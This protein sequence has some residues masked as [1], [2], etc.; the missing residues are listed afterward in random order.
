MGVFR[1]RSDLAILL[2]SK[3]T[4]LRP[5]QP[6]SARIP[7]KTCDSVILKSPRETRCL[8]FTRR[9]WSP[10]ANVTSK[11]LGL[12]LGRG[13]TTDVLSPGRNSAALSPLWAPLRGSNHRGEHLLSL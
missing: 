3:T 10:P 5:L 6:C 7:E 12:V 9:L 4:I 11:S 1:D 13:K 2:G 8:G